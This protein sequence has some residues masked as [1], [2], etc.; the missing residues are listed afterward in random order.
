MRI[1]DFFH[2]IVIDALSMW[3]T[4][5]REAK[6]WIRKWWE[7]SW[8]VWISI[9]ILVKFEA[10]I[11]RRKFMQFFFHSL[12][13]LLTFAFQHEFLLMIPLENFIFLI[14]SLDVSLSIDGILHFFYA[15]DT[16]FICDF[17]W[18][19]LYFHSF[20][21]F[22]AINSSF[23]SYFRHLGRN[24][25]FWCE[26]FVLLIING[27]DFKRIFHRYRIFFWV[28]LIMLSPIAQCLDSVSRVT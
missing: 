11:D 7:L 15:I 6:K 8:M 9:K 14:L 13:S 16:F 4:K 21:A 26:I 12:I 5:K 25:Q 27:F 24:V 20:H 17:I 28:S 18:K 19:F 10:S 22:W 3:W 23:F 1:K 2:L